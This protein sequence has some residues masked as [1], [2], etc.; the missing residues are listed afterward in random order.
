MVRRVG[1]VGAEGPARRS[2]RIVF[3]SRPGGR[4]GVSFKF[5]FEFGAWTDARGAWDED[6]IPDELEAFPLTRLLS[7]CGRRGRTAASARFSAASVS[8]S[9]Y[10]A[11]DAPSRPSPRALRARQPAARR[12]LQ[13]RSPRPRSTSAT[14]PRAGARAGPGRGRRPRR[15]ARRGTGPRRGRRPRRAARLHRRRALVRDDGGGVHPRRVVGRSARVGISRRAARRAHVRDHARGRRRARLRQPSV[16]RRAHRHRGATRHQ[17]GVFQPRV[18]ARVLLSRR[19]VAR[20]GSGAESAARFTAR[21]SSDD[22]RL[23]RSEQ[24]FDARASE[25]SDV[26]GGGTARNGRG[27]RSSPGSPRWRTFPGR[28]R[29]R[30]PGWGL[31]RGRV[32]AFEPCPRVPRGRPERGRG[33]RGCSARPRAA[34]SRRRGVRTPRGGTTTRRVVTRAW[35]SAIAPSRRTSRIRTSRTR[36]A[37]GF[38]RDPRF[39]AS[40]RRVCPRGR[41]FLRGTDFS[42][43]RTSARWRGISSCSCRRCPCSP[44]FTT[45][46]NTYQ[47]RTWCWRGCG[48]VHAVSGKSPR[49]RLSILASYLFTHPRFFA[50]LVTSVAATARVGLAPLAGLAPTL[51]AARGV[52][53]TAASASRFDLRL[54]RE[55]GAATFIGE[56][57]RRFSPCS[58][59]TRRRAQ[60]QSGDGGEETRT[61]GARAIDA[62]ARVRGEAGMTSPRTPGE[63]ARARTTRESPGRGDATRVEG[64]REA[65][66][67]G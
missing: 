15:D 37:R 11:A 21:K 61:R 46:T 47:A 17:T 2:R 28:G 59:P 44:D 63:R 3:V 53:R 33:R 26:G 9:W 18:G 22:R 32:F 48:A 60:D 57:H 58:P 56:A 5:D 14:H 13:I 43:G 24:R 27:S 20:R 67:R 23:H 45:C 55:L 50:P 52:G 49:A 65:H 12:R 8:C 30:K 29:E 6:D 10:S 25:V 36:C 51:F 66:E 34:P 38:E 16:C 40:A 62:R 7:G 42:T 35:C 19:A 54:W 1:C 41:F 4:D 64:A 39:F 31:R